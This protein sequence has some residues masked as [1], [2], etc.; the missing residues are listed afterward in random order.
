[1]TATGPSTARAT[2][3]GLASGAALLGAFLAL[4]WRDLDATWAGLD[5]NGALF[6][7]FLGPYWNTARGLAAGEPSPAPGYLYPA[8]GAWLLAPLA[9]LGP[10]GASWL[11]L[12]LMTGAAALL[13]ASLLRLRPARS[14]GEAALVGAAV[15]LAH[16][17][18]HGAYWGQAALPVT[19]LSVAAFAAW[20][21]GRSATGGALVGVA[22]AVKLTPLV[23]L[24]APAARRDGRAL[25]AGLG[26]F[27]ACAVLVPALLM[28]PADLVAFHAE[29]A[30][31]LR[32]LAGSASTGVGGRGSQDPGAL[33]ARLAG[34][35]AFWIGK[36]AGLGVSALAVRA[37]FQELREAAPSW[38][39]ALVLLAAVPWLLVT[40][41]WA[42]GLA[43]SVV[44]WRLGWAAGGAA[45]AL[46][47]GSALLGTLP[48]LRVVADP[49]LHA[50]LGLPAAAAA[51][52]L[53]AAALAAGGDDGADTRP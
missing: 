8:F 19:A 31:Q 13:L 3:I 9:G 7:D 36:A 39:R 46:A 48:L 20:R 17:V 35:G 15:L 34:D 37:A 6:E 52:A 45:R 33:L 5:F 22:A 47:L 26:A 1:V 42:H 49:V 53:A 43:W 25:V 50:S 21:A 16:P 41:T 32:E 40:P 24:L 27:V 30:A 11:C 38:E 2:A 28:G 10:A 51:L 14:D 12:G 44:A 29:A 4:G 23:L 18:V